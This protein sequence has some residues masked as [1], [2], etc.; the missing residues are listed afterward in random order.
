M[1]PQH[2]AKRTCRMLTI[3]VGLS[4]SLGPALAQ[5]GP[6]DGPGESATGRQSLREVVITARRSIEER[7]QATGSLVVVDRQDIEQMGVDNAVD[8]LRQ[9]PGLQV[10]TGASGNVEIRMRGL[11]GSATRV[12]IDGQRSA[13]RAQLP[14]DQLPA[15]L[16][17]RIEIV[18][19]P[20]AEFSG[21]SGGTV[22][23]VLRQAQPQRTAM[24]RLTDTITWGEHR[25]RLWAMRTGPLAGEASKA[26]SPPPWSFFM[27]VW[28]AQ[29]INGFDQERDTLRDGLLTET[30]T[31]S[32]TQRNDWM[33]IPRLSG[34]IGRD[35]V[36]LRGNISGSS[37]DGD[38]R[39]RNASS[40]LMNSE[41]SNSQR[42][43]WQLG[44]DWTRRLPIGKLETSLSGNRQSDE[45]DRQRDTG[46]TFREDRTESTWQ[47]RSKLTGSR[48]SLL[49]MTGFEHENR[50]ASGS[51]LDSA[52]SR[53]AEQLSS[54][55][56]RSA[57]WGQNEWELPRKTTL[58]LGLRRESVMLRSQV[59]ADQASQRVDFWQPSL[60]TRTPISETAQWRL[61]IARVTRQPSVWDLLDRT[62][63][64]QGANSV[65]NADQVGN[66]NLR[67]EVT[68]TF[69]VGLEQ[70]LAGQG[71]AGVSLFMRQTDDVIATQTFEQNGRWVDQRQN[72][73]SAR[74]VGLEG[75]LKRPLAGS[76]WA[77]DWMLSVNA[78]VLQSRMTDG[79]RDGMAIPG[80]PSYTASLSAARPMRRS[81]G[82]FGGLAANLTGPASLSTPGVSG[83]EPSRLTFD[84]HIGHSVP[85]VGFWRLGIYNLSDA[86][87]RR[88][89]S[90]ESGGSSITDHTRTLYAPRIYASVG[91]QL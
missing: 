53:G 86:P 79:A 88:S 48:G 1:Q 62:V 58:T 2:I 19:S 67:P 30:Q 29:S 38:Y 41:T 31:R 35:Q 83:R 87:V 74:T 15:D 91:L 26:G 70:R 65:T 47:L 27:G 82:T 16:I 18:R 54:R 20:S 68:Q 9:L 10:T 60:H 78:T 40:G 45:L 17:E 23:I 84:A 90:Y 32:R 75:D 11:D 61:N 85:R 71:Q 42:N 3:L 57:L 22:N 50:Q 7:F 25:P 55:I 72:I 44:G 36:A 6:E 81:G 4:G 37:T 13:G 89:R 8:V 39:Q 46:S 63:P 73:G 34:R 12:L 21:S 43:S 51:S 28:L 24:A 69:D 49:W 59:N 76:G 52:S 5:M 77:R 14:I 64:S 33:L 66:P 80:Q 56:E